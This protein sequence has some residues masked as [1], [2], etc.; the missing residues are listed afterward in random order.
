M[1]VE[2]DDDEIIRVLK[3]MGMPRNCTKFILIAEV[4]QPVKVIATYFPEP[5][6]HPDIGI[7]RMLVTKRFKLTEI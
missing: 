1:S 7:Q 5:N 4:D 6:F 3:A 2:S